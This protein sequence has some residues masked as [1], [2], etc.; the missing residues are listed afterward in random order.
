M[1]YHVRNWVGCSN[2]A[3]RIERIHRKKKKS[4]N[5]YVLEEGSEKDA[6]PQKR[7]GSECSLGGFRKCLVL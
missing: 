2:V 4:N 1:M 7:L 3:N 5:Y 6:V